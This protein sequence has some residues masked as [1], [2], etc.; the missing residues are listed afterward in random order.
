MNNSPDQPKSSSLLSLSAWRGVASYAGC[1]VLVVAG[2]YLIYSGQWIAGLLAWVIAALLFQ[3]HRFLLTIQLFTRN[4][5]RVISGERNIHFSPS[6]TTSIGY[7]GRSLNVLNERMRRLENKRDRERDRLNT[8]LTRMTGGALLLNRHG[9]VRM[10]NPAAAEFLRVD[11]QNALRKSLAQVVWD[12]RITEVWQ[13]CTKSGVEENETIDLDS[14][15]SVR[16]TVTPFLKG[17]DRGHLVLL[18]DLSHVRRLEKIR[19][20]FVSNVSHELRTPLASL[21]AL[22]DTL[23]DGALDD[24]PAAT[25]F[26]GRI[27]V[28]VDKMTQMVEELLELSRIESGQFPL[29]L[30][31]ASIQEIVQPSVERLLPQAQRAGVTITV[32]LPTDLPSVLADV[33]RMHQVVINLVH[34]AIKFTPSDGKITVSACATQDNQIAVSVQDTGIGIPGRDI[35]RIFERFYKTDR[36]RSGGGTGLGLAIS[37]HIVQVHH[38]RI[39]V[40]SQEGVGSTFTFSLPTT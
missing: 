10:I 37:K 34:N 22:V 20:D 1:L 16:V 31:T 17:S 2:G 18:Q 23:R 21:K 27:E 15:R 39:W 38:G 30:T 3:L 32:D 11:S 26:L 25:H 19:R 5:T 12:Y 28:E 8:L 35:S 24:P 6:N 29:R 36:A 13:R 7:L 4:V 9:R 40:E 14:G 33:E